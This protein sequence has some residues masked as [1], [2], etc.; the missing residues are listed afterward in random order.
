MPGG[1]SWLSV[2]YLPLLG[3]QVRMTRDQF[4]LRQNRINYTNY[5]YYTNYTGYTNYTTL[6]TKVK[7]TVQNCKTLVYAD[8]RNTLACIR[9]RL[10][11]VAI[12]SS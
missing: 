10:V 9:L 3:N 11:C 7:R 8:L 2:L 1:F 5:T 6:I 4:G 12:F